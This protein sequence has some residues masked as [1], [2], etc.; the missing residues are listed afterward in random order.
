MGSGD[1]TASPARSICQ[2]RP[3]RRRFAL[4]DDAAAAINTAP[5]PHNC[6]DSGTSRD[7]RGS[8][9]STVLANDRAPTEIVAP[10]ATTI[11]A[12]CASRLSAF[13]RSRT[14]VMCVIPSAA[15]CSSRVPLAR[16]F[17]IFPLDRFAAHRA[18][19]FAKSLS[20]YTSPS[21]RSCGLSRIS[22]LIDFRLTASRLL[23]RARA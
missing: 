13:A 20:S 7:I 12:S 15:S 19:H 1:A 23:C 21:R 8:P 14:L 17:A 5:V 16:T 9:S 4:R 11:A 18:S 22:W 3:I 6:A 10:I 2:P